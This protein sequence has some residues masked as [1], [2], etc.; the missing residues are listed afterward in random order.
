M[1]DNKPDLKVVAEG[2]PQLMELM[3]EFAKDCMNGTTKAI[4]IVSIDGDGDEIFASWALSDNES[5]CKLLGATE[6]L[7]TKM[8]DSMRMGHDD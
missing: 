1:S 2:N 5:V 6:V 7:R 8:I 3:E 4:A